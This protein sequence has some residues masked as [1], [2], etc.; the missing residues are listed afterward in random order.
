MA[1][2][3]VP[4]VKNPNSEISVNEAKKD[5]LKPTKN[6]SRVAKRPRDQKNRGFLKPKDFKTKQDKAFD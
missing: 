1:I 6:D 3:V 5:G 4:D 2:D